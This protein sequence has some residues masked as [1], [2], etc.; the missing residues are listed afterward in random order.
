MFAS[1]NSTDLGSYLVDRKFIDKPK[2]HDGDDFAAAYSRIVVM[3]LP[4]HVK[5][6]GMNLRGS[7]GSV[8]SQ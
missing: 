8:W 1:L 7:R 2:L 4:P 3:G 6:W 5:H